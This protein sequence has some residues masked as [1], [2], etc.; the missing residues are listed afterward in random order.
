MC[1]CAC[2]CVSVPVSV[3]VSLCLCLP[4]SL[5]LSLDCTCIVYAGRYDFMQELWIDAATTIFYLVA[6]LSVY[7]E[8]TAYLLISFVRAPAPIVWSF[9]ACC[10]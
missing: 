1:A 7:Q 3:S 9:Y 5:N 4:A 10:G 2:A 8:Q 6:T